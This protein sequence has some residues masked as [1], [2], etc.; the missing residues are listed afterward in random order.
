MNVYILFIIPQLLRCEAESNPSGEL[1]RP[2]LK[3]TKPKHPNYAYI[4]I[5]VAYLV[6]LA[7][8]VLA[9]GSSWSSAALP[10]QITSILI[11]YMPVGF[12]FYD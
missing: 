10:S 4:E 6:I 5:F 11:V 8:I 3:E 7:L 1:S 12:S 2:G 9:S